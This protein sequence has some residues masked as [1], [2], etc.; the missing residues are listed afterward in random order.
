LVYKEET[1]TFPD[2]AEKRKTRRLYGSNDRPFNHGPS[3]RVARSG[4]R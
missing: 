4:K 1:S 3:S 2:Q